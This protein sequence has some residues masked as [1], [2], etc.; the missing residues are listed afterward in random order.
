MADDPKFDLLNSIGGWDGFEVAGVRRED[1]L[2]PDVLGLPSERLIIELRAKPGAPKRCSRCGSVIAE[3]HDVSERCVRDLPIWEL[4][5]WL[6]VPRARLECPRCG[7]TSE[8]CSCFSRASC[9]RCL[10]CTIPSSSRSASS[11]CTCSASRVC[12]SPSR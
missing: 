8:R 10:G 12:S 1:A 9:W 2:E 3:I 7:P 6:I 5:T 4:D 11:C